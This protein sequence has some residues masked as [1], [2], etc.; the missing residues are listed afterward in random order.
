[1]ARRIRRAACTLFVICDDL[2]STDCAEGVGLQNH[3][4]MHM[5]L[6]SAVRINT[7]KL[8]HCLIVCCLA[9]SAAAYFTAGEFCRQDRWP[10]Q[11]LQAAGHYTGRP[12][13]AHRYRQPAWSVIVL[14][15]NSCGSTVITTSG[16][17]GT[18]GSLSDSCQLT[19]P[20]WCEQPPT[21]VCLGA[22]APTSCCRPDCNAAV[23]PTTQAEDKSQLDAVSRC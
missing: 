13:V 17:T 14:S 22:T 20:T 15:S 11:Q 3:H 1:M 8:G 19:C 10:Q 9:P 23:M 16:P 21:P 12:N 2:W 7:L 6:P 18:G 4:S 5:P